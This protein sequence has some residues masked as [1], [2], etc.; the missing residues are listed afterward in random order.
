MVRARRLSFLHLSGPRRGE[1]DRVA[2]PALIGSDAGTAVRVPGAAPRHAFLFEREDEMV[3]QDGGSGSGTLVGGEPVQEAVLR[4]GDVVELGSGGPRLRLRDEDAAR[5]SLV[6]ALAWARPE[7]VRV[8]D[9]RG[10]AR[11]LVRET[12]SRTTPSFRR[13]LAGVLALGVLVLAG[14]EWQARSVRLELVRLREALQEVEA[15]RQRFYARIEDERRRAETD[16]S[17]LEARIE[18]LRQRE[19]RLN[20]RLAEAA[21]GEVGAVRRDL[22]QTR[23]RLASLESE[24]AVGERIIREYG[25]GVCLIQGAYAFYDKDARPL[26]YRLEKGTA[27]RDDE[28]NPALD[29]AGAGSVHVVEYFG[30]GFLVDRRGLVLTNRHLAEP[31]WNDRAAD[32]LASRGFVPRFTLFRAFFPREA[33]PFEL[34][35][36]RHA[37]ASD[38]SLLRLDLRGRRIPALPLDRSGRGAVAGQPVV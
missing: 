37:E 15:E 23:G 22:E 32:A 3:L 34:E 26:R 31:W 4:D 24:R 13:T 10:F 35:V 9:L 25:H 20:R 29:P 6:Q 5:I 33:E 38:L 16:R 7:G 12:A 14:T 36:V 28:G 11:A 2:L 18:E 27:V 8:S 21:A 17:A 19:E 30:T 1:V